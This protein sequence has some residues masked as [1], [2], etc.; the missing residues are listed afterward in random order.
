MNHWVFVIND[1]EEE[2]EHRIQN[3]Q[4]PIYNK[5]QNRKKIAIG[6]KVVFYMAG[7]KGQ[8]FLG[9]A[10][11]AS[12]LVQ[13]TELTYE[14]KLSNIKVWQKPLQLRNVIDRLEFVKNKQNFGIYFQGGVRGLTEN[15]Y[16]LIL[17]KA[18][19]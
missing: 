7:E 16:F 8:K 4:W 12:E 10:S 19:S 18:G 2:L 17:S 9:T 15:D 11:I 5:T 6:D 1:T 3:N 14:L 13:K